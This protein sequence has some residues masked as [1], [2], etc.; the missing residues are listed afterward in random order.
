MNFSES[1]NKILDYA[2]K[3]VL[4]IFLGKNYR[5]IIGALLKDVVS[6]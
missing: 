4:I 3:L 5:K 6:S 1:L 2:I